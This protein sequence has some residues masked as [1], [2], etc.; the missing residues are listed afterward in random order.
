M[1]DAKQSVIFGLSRL[2][3]RVAHSLAEMG[4][5]VRLIHRGSEDDA[6]AGLLPPSVGVV[7]LLADNYDASLREAVIAQAECLL[8]LGEDDLANLHAA[9]AA[10]VARVFDD[11]LADRLT[12]TFAI[13]RALSAS[14]ASVGAF[15]GAALDERALRP[16]VV[17]SLSLLACRYSVQIPLAQ[18]TLSEWRSRGVRL[19][20]YHTPPDA[21]HPPST[22]AGALEP[23]AQAILCGPADA[24]LAIVGGAHSGAG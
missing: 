18:S 21:L 4:A 11:T 13:T 15:V 12:E 22:L 23:G 10:T 14:Q 16:I 1:P 2:S 5:V 20:A 8:V 9:V 24:V 19:L 7:P 3:V 6:L 17:G